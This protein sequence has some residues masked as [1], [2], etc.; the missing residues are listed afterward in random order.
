MIGAKMSEN[1]A[2]QGTHSIYNIHAKM[3]KFTKWKKSEK[4]SLMDFK[5]SHMH[6][7]ILYIKHLQSF[8]M[9]GSKV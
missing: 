3:T 9:N 6:T 2:G 4:N 7:F 8:K 5:K 1:S